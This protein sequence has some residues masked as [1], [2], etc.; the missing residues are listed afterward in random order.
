MFHRGVGKARIK[1]LVVNEKLDLL[2]DY[3]AMRL[4]DKVGARTVSTSACPV[5]LCT[6]D[7]HTHQVLYQ[8]KPCLEPPPRLCLPFQLLCFLPSW[9]WGRPPPEARASGGGA[10]ADD[11]DALDAASRRLEHM[12]SALKGERVGGKYIASNH[13]YAKVRGSGGGSSGSGSGA[14]DSAR[15]S[16][17]PTAH[18]RPCTH[19]NASPPP[20]LTP[21]VVERMTLKRQCPTV[22]TLLKHFPVPMELQEPTFKEIVVVYR[23]AGFRE[24]ALNEKHKAVV[25]GS[26]AQQTCTTHS[27]RMHDA[28]AHTCTTHTTNKPSQ[29][30]PRR[31]QARRGR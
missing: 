20:S 9:L 5:A 14:R 25:Q 15:C 12:S 27:W 21:Q 16:H 3:T 19:M 6:V 26:K 31:A 1:G 13:K 24:S 2:T 17:F 4:L 11:S 23:W 18:A 28:H 8:C 30:R 7:A 10:A 29:A 22:L